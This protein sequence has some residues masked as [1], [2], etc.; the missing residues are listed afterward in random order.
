V[1]VILGENIYKS[2]S[3]GAKMELVT[4]EGV[5]TTKRNK[6]SGFQT[7]SLGHFFDNILIQIFY[8]IEKALKFTS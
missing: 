6:W 3:I 5:V 2:N 8:F 4:V 1:N 7:L